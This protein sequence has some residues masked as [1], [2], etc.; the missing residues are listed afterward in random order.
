MKA[1]GSG[2]ARKGR[3]VLALAAA[4]VALALSAHT[5][6]VQLTVHS[7]RVCRPSQLGVDTPSRYLAPAGKFVS[8]VIQ[9]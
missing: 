6:W 3:H 9:V 8:I 7:A 4:S 1:L 2:W 5:L